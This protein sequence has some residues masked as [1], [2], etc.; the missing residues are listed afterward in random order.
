MHQVTIFTWVTVCM[1][2]HTWLCFSLISCQKVQSMR[3][4]LYLLTPSHTPF[5][6]LVALS[7]GLVNDD[8][9]EERTMS[10]VFLCK[11]RPGG[12]YTILLGFRL[13]FQKLNRRCRRFS[14]K[15]V[16]SQAF[17][18]VVI[19]LVFL[20]TVVLTSEH[21]GQPEWLDEF[22]GQCTFRLS[23]LCNVDHC[24]AVISI[25]IQIHSEQWDKLTVLCWIQDEKS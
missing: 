9:E 3:C 11:S 17:Y 12:K 19:V 1:S 2:S 7:W 6:I 14:R 25:H 5:N 22:Q 16:K 8:E 4:R 23:V 13:R 20:N 18:W 15:I 10:G 24:V 21:Y